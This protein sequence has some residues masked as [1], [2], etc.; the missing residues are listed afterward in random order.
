MRNGN[1]THCVWKMGKMCFW[2]SQG[3]LRS[4]FSSLAKEAFA[5]LIASWWYREVEERH[6]GVTDYHWWVGDWWGMPSL[7]EDASIPFLLL[8]IAWRGFKKISRHHHRGWAVMK[9]RGKWSIFIYAWRSS[10][11][12][13]CFV[14]K[15]VIVW[16]EGAWRRELPC[17]WAFEYHASGI[18]IAF[19]AL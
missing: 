12:G 18:K 10:V 9:L 2:L 1:I 8:A 4:F 3:I 13:E 16:R 11:V 14:S 19:I 17:T 6:S 5:A 15:S 7:R